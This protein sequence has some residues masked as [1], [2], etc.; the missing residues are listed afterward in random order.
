MHLQHKL[1]KWVGVIGLMGLCSFTYTCAPRDYRPL[2]KNPDFY[3]STV[4][5]LTEV[6]VYDIF[7]PPVASRVYAYPAIA[8]YE[9]LRHS[10]SDYRSLAGQL[11]GLSATPAPPQDALVNF[12]LASLQAYMTVG[13]T[14]VFSEDKMDSYQAELLEQFAD[15]GMPDDVLERS[16]AYGNTVA[17]HILAWADKD[18]YKQTRT[19]PKYTLNYALGKWLPTPPDYMEGIEPSWMKMR[20][21][22]LD[23]AS[24]FKPAPPTEVTLDEKGAFFAE[25]QEVY[26]TVENLTEEQQAIASFWDCNPF[27]THPIGH[28]NFASKKISPGG[29]WVEIVTQVADNEEL[30]MME[31]VAAQAR[32][33]IAIFDAFISC[34]DEKWRSVYIRPETF[35]NQ[36]IDEDWVPFLQTPPFPEY[37]SGHSV[38]SAASA[39]T[40]TDLLGDNYSFSDSTEMLYGLQPRQFSSFNA[41]AEEAALSRLYGGI[42]FRPAIDNGV[43]QGRQI[44]KLHQRKLVTKQAPAPLTAQSD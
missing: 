6:I 43:V 16:V 3:H 14:L 39:A 35:I 25:A 37:P 18:N 34:W 32:V 4:R 31:S 24:Q 21:M 10:H 11:N 28:A 22:L 44:A 2:T 36:N 20:P 15:T 41:A 12:E 42:H 7:S 8:A 1:L 29:H 13:K 17:T 9:T 23:S 27:V 40:L 30:S 38:V 26:N 33:S 19:F 5:K